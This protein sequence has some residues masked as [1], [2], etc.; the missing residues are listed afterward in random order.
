MRSGSAAHDQRQSGIVA[1]T[2]GQT[3]GP[4]LDPI[5]Q[6]RPL[7]RHPCAQPRQ[8]KSAVVVPAG[9]ADRVGD[10]AALAL[11]VGSAA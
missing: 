3:G 6:R 5:G 8:H 7:A 11:V 1:H 10:Y 4:N 9:L 2:V